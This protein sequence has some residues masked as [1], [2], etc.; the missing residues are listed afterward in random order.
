MKTGEKEKG[1]V[2]WIQKKKKE[3]KWKTELDQRYERMEQKLT[4]QLDPAM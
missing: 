4:L 3:L 2:L 1:A